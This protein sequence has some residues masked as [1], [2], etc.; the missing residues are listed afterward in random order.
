MHMAI[1]AN[2]STRKKILVVDN[3]PVICT[4]L[5]VLLGDEFEVITATN[6]N[7]A[8]HLADNTSPDIVL[9]DIMMPSPDGYEVCT[10]LKQ[11][12]KTSEVP[13][14][15]LT[16]IDDD[17]NESKC[18]SLGAVDYIKKPFSPSIVRARVRTQLNLKY[19]R[20]QLQQ[21]TEH[22]SKKIDLEKARSQ[23]EQLERERQVKQSA[24]IHSGRLA[25]IGEMATCMAHEIGNPLNAINIILQ[26]WESQLS[27]EKF[28]T[29]T[30]VKDLVE[31]KENVKRISRLTSH[32][33]TFG[34]AKQNLV[35]I[36][37]SKVVREAVSL[38]RMQH[39]S[40]SIEFHEDF[41][42]HLPTVRIVPAEL[43]QVILN[44]LSNAC[45]SL[46]SLN[47]KDTKP[48]LFVQIKHENDRLSIF[49][50]DNGGGVPEN[51]V[52]KIFDPF[53]TTKPLSKGTGLGLSIS[54]DIM[55]KFH[56][57]LT[58]HNHPGKGA[59]F[60]AWLPLPKLQ[61]VDK[62]S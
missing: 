25:A 6:G 55:Q 42:E 5:G 49:I 57:G 9:L 47:K 34:R 45:Y 33:R 37:V 36:E 26:K 56:G 62:A 18:L 51:K 1:K 24:M 27:N 32:I 14:I 54:K 38:C 39:H 10:A 40:N 31:L 59:K 28:S 58:L 23:H 30:L 29:E 60:E 13:V 17:Q 4:L 20:D 8:I 15:F 11:N 16:A 7:D 41:A 35:D 21:T 48:T 46:E 52:D 43:E 12:P 50:E 61:E 2:S 3:N 44:L 19:Q 22:L 53:Y